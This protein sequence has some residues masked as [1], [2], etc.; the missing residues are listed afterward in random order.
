[1]YIHSVKLTNYKSIGDYPETEVI[2]EPTV[3][4]IVGKNESGKSNVLDG[5]SQIDFLENKTNAYAPEK[6]NRSASDGSQIEYT[7]LI[8]PSSS[9]IEKGIE[10]DTI[11][12][13]SKNDYKLTGGFF[14]CYCRDVKS[15]VDALN[16]IIESFGG[17]PFK[18]SGQELAN[19]KKFV[20]VLK[21][22]ESLNVPLFLSALFYFRNRKSSVE[23]ELKDSFS[24]A[25]ETVERKMNNFLY[26]SDK[27]LFHIVHNL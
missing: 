21:A 13:L 10:E 9:D 8:K 17:N 25:L 22:N 26:I 16:S 27:Y 11:I 14:T 5:L 19:Y 12:V 2:L 15:Y 6:L 1:M 23:A 3:T 7:V 20:D 4:A 18:L 24:E